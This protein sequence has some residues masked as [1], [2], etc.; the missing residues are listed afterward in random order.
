[1]TRLL[2]LLAAIL[3][4]AGCATKTQSRVG[5]DLVTGDYAVEELGTNRFRITF[6]GNVALS[7]TAAGDL[8]LLHAAEV[9]L[10][11]GYPYFVIVFPDPRARNSVFSSSY[12]ITTGPTVTHGSSDFGN[13]PIAVS[14]IEG[15]KDKLTT[16]FGKVFDA[17]SLA[18]TLREKY[19]VKE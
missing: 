8:N 13:Y 19:R 2:L 4:L 3:L 9:A 17:E 16:P 10:Q 7:D 11:H 1:M 18:A 14:M 12:V 6:R 5:G 15:L